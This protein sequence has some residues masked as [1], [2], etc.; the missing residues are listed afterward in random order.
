MTETILF[1]HFTIIISLKNEIE[2]RYLSYLQIANGFLTK[3]ELDSDLKN[4]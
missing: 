2:F 3:W 1:L 4:H